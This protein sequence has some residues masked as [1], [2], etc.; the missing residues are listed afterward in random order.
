MADANISFELSE[1]IFGERL[2]DQPHISMYFYPIAIGDSNAR[3]FLATV[4]KGEKTEEDK[5]SYIHGMG[6]NAKDATLL[7]H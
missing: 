1:I 2:G 6:V 5:A 3:T 4:L 7:M